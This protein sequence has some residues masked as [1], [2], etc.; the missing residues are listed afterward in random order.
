MKIG[1]HIV[2]VFLL[3]FLMFCFNNYLMIVTAL[4]EGSEQYQDVAMVGTEIAETAE[5]LTEYETEQ[6][7]TALEAWAEQET[8]DTQK[9]VVEKKYTLIGTLEEI[10]G[11]EIVILTV[12]GNMTRIS[13]ALAEIDVNNGFQIG[14]LIAVNCKDNDEENNGEL[15]QAVRIADTADM[16]LPE[17]T[18]EDGN[19]EDAVEDAAES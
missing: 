5:E 19:K 15:K 13:T 10:N 12:N 8:H 3:L 14:N 1:K 4:P 2:P 18:N 7:E 11:E 6:V 17:Y 9:S 16:Q